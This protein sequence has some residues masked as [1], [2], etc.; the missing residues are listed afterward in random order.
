MRLVQVFAVGGSQASESTSQQQ[1]K[2]VKAKRIGR[3]CVVIGSMFTLSWTP[4]QLFLIMLSLG[5]SSDL[6]NLI[7]TLAFFP[8]L[9]SCINPMIYGLMWKPL[10]QALQQASD[11]L[12]RPQNS[13]YGVTDSQAESR[14]APEL[15][16]FSFKKSAIMIYFLLVVTI[17]T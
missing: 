14:N 9:N 5:F 4:I 8:A 17:E 11:F 13:M 6:T 1:Q 12:F 16:F 3:L 15:K 7:P 10:Q 2:Q